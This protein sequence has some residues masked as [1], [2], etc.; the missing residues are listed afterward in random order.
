MWESLI[1][2]HYA[3]KRINGSI[4]VGGLPWFIALKGCCT[5]G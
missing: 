1:D 2:L 5:D 3:T 4:A